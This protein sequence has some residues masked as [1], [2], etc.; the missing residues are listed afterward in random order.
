[1]K[2]EKLEQSKMVACEHLLIFDVH[3]ATIFA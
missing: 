2:R 3:E 1:M